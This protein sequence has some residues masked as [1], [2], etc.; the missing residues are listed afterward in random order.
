[1]LMEEIDQVKNE[2]VDQFLHPNKMAKIFEKRLGK[3]YR[4][5]FSAYKTPKLNPDDMTV[6]AYF[7]PEGPKKIEIVLVYSSG[8]KRGLKIHED[9]WEHLA[10]RI[11]QAYQ[12]ELI[13]KKQWK[14]K[15]NKREKDRNYFTDPAEIDAHAHDIALEFLF[16]GFTVEEAINN[17]KNYKSVCLTESIT[18]FSYLVYFQYEDHP[19]LRK[20]I[21]RTVYYLENK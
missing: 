2:I 18:L 8:I 7:D 4:A 16:N 14:K 1:M 5:I 20:L 15:K 6:N 11:Y 17:L 9:G 21:K 10:F 12:H 13:H 3:K 19:A